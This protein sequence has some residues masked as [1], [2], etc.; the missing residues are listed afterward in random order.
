[1]PIFPFRP[2]LGPEFY[3]S[4]KMS[5]P[6]HS[7]WRN[8][9]CEEYE[10]DD[11]LY[12]FVM[13][14]NISTDLGKKQAYYLMHDKERSFH[15]QRV[16]QDIV[17]FIYGPGNRCFKSGDHRIQS[18]RPP[19]YLVS[20]G[21]WRGNPRGTPTF[22]HRRPEDWADDCGEHQLRIAETVQKGSYDG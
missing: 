11:F 17:K 9:T 19:F 20:G 10:C 4:Y 1:M 18:G 22:Q 14:A 7:H 6:L 2:R 12:G 3:K 8:A 15:I 13:T 16:S 21:D 5:A